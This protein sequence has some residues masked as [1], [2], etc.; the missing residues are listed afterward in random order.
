MASLLKKKSN[1]YPIYAM[2]YIRLRSSY[3]KSYGENLE[4]PHHL[5]TQYRPRR[6][7]CDVALNVILWKD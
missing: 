6:T 1:I 3:G 7:F 5:E 2:K 4:S